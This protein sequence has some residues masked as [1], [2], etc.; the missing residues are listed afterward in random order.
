MSS[1]NQIV[2][3]EM[4]AVKRMELDRQI[5]EAMKAKGCANGEY[6]KL[7]LGFELPEGW[8]VDKDSEITMAQ[9]IVLAQ[10]LDL[11]IVINDLCMMPRRKNDSNSG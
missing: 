11:K 6:N 8:P 5:S 7:G 9:L 10:K 3:V 2:S 1:E 4:T